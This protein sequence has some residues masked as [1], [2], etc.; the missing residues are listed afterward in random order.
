MPW[1]LQILTFYLYAKKIGCGVKDYFFHVKFWTTRT[2]FA[3]YSSRATEKT[4]KKR[5]GLLTR[6]LF[7]LQPRTLG[8][9]CNV[10]VL[11]CTLDN[12]QEWWESP[13]NIC[14]Y[15]HTCHDLS[16]RPQNCVWHDINM[17]IMP[18]CLPC[19]KYCLWIQ[20]AVAS[21]RPSCQ[22]PAG[23]QLV[24]KSEPW[25]QCNS[26]C[27]SHI[28]TSRVG[29]NH[30]DTPSP[31]GMKGKFFRNARHTHATGSRDVFIAEHRAWLS[32][33]AISRLQQIWSSTA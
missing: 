31:I 12:F 3:R 32:A 7:S 23:S 29:E 30:L 20:L 33:T 8:T 21:L 27:I 15:A 13:G 25:S 11:L 14:V 4:Q 17:F 6:P 1:T 9:Y 5:L 24:L 26:F 10:T 22:V 18:R 16:A 28:L 19:Y 2:A